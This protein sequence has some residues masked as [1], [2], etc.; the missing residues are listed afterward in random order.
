MSKMLRSTARISWGIGA[1]GSAALMLNAGKRVGAPGILMVLFPLWVLSPFVLLAVVGVVSKRWTALTH[2]TVYRMTPIISAAS[3]AIYGA[4]A[5]G[6]PRP[7]TAIFV[8]VAPVS[9]LFI[10]IAVAAAAFLAR[11]S[12]AASLSE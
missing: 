8:L 6:A 3:L 9:C 2:A 11:R 10:V 5:L 1:A 12:K 7:K 4:T